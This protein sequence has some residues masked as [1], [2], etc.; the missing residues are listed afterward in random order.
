MR[1]RRL[2]ILLTAALAALLVVLPATALAGPPVYRDPPTFKPLKK[3]PPTQA[4]KPAPPVKL[5]SSGTNPNVLVDEAGTAHIVWND[6]QGDGADVVRYCRLK[7]GAKSCDATAT[8]SWNKT[9]GPGDSPSFNIDDGGPRIVRVGNQLVVLSKRY[10]TFADKPDGTASSS[11]V[12]AWISNDGGSTWSDA[13]ITGSRNLGQLVVLPPTDDPTILNL[14]SD[15]LC[16]ADGGP[17]CLEAFHSGTFSPVTDEGT[18]SQSVN[19]AY[20]P[21]LALDGST[22]FAAFGDL[23][24]HVIIRGWSGNGSVT[25]G[26]QWTRTV[27]GGTEPH[28]AGGA[29][30][31]QLMSRPELSGPYRLQALT[32]NGS[33]V[34]VG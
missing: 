23:T 29:A 26:N 14:G 2:A 6:P 31:L 4:P 25:D 13:Q 27:A 5:A 7:R 22:P 20:D 24:D 9:Y 11:T 1:S 34:T 30:G 15:P 3:I 8:L 19:E 17:M 32:P 12:L 10:P 33:G 18:L 28:L 16:P 21:G